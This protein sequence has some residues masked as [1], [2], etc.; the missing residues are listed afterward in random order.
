MVM[1]TIQI[2]LNHAM[3]EKIDSEVKSGLYSSRSDFVRDAVRKQIHAMVG[4]IP[5]TGDSVKEVREVRK[6]LSKEMFDIDKINRL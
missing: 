3:I 1:D 5:N 4:T 6:K 2:R